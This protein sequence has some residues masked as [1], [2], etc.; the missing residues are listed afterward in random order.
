MRLFIAL[1][2]S[3]KQRH[4]LA[5]FQAGF[6]NQFK[7]VRWIKPENMH[8]TLKFI[9]ETDQAGVNSITDAMDHVVQT[10]QPL[11]TVYSS[12]GVFPS[13]A[14]ARILWVGLNRDVD[15]TTRIAEGLDSFLSGKGFKKRSSCLKLT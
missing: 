2:L 1:E 13:P 4:E 8:L 15:R 11:E 3:E 12:C 6:K 14:G 5:K 7:G 10:E 9:G